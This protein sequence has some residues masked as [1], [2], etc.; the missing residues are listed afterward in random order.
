MISQTWPF[1][2][3]DGDFW[4][5]ISGTECLNY[6]YLDQNSPFINAG[7]YY[8]EQTHQVGKTTSIN[9][10]PD[11]NYI[12]LGFHYS[13]WFYTNAGQTTLIAD[14]DANCVID[15]NDLIFFVNHWL[16][17]FNSGTFDRVADL[18]KDG[19]IDFFDFSALAN[20]WM[21]TGEPDPNIEI[22]IYG[23]S[24]DGYINAGVYNFSP[25]TEQI[26]IYLDGE[27]LG[28]LMNFMDG[29]TFGI[30]TIGYGNGLHELKAVSKS[31]DGRITCSNRKS[32]YFNSLLSGLKC[33][34]DYRVDC[35][36]YFSGIYSGQNL[37]QVSVVDIEGNTAW[38]NTYS[39]N[40]NGFI[41]AGT[42]TSDGFYEIIFEEVPDGMFLLDFNESEYKSWVK[43]VSEKFDVGKY[44]ANNKSLIVCPD[45]DVTKGK[46]EA[47]QAAEYAFRFKNLKPVI[48]YLKNATYDNLT[49]CLKKL[50]IR[51]LYF[52]GHG[53]YKAPNKTTVT[54]VK[55]YDGLMVAYKRIDF[56]DPNIIPDGP[57]YNLGEWEK[58]A[59]SA[60]RMGVP[61]GK[62]KI[63]FFD[64]CY[65]ARKN[66]LNSP[67][68]DMSSTLGIYAN[69]R[70]Q[71]YIGW[72]NEAYINDI[73]NFHCYNLWDH[74]LWEHLRLDESF[75]YAL[76]YAN[77]H[78]IGVEH[79]GLEA[80]VDNYEIRGIPDMPSI[81]LR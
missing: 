7:S 12:N 10:V 36:Y 43:K 70:S 64:A 75:Y 8:I 23:D 57:S 45:K 31:S 73:P 53:G 17:D 24:N 4:S 25:S 65:S 69:D 50:P 26:F 80:P 33:S 16:S 44:D 68:G 9:G 49:Y 20:Q 18:N 30:E 58:T 52:V 6:F 32:V 27:Y 48:L 1:V 40:I 54:S 34:D 29:Q 51:H 41:P 74:L 55:L 66:I 2:H 19:S 14:F 56:I 72:K 38:S 42:F 28:E 79:P 5:I 76:I 39:D 35:N 11:S 63:T 61:T 77:E 46:F 81:Y 37:L 67:H 3:S 21:S 60:L 78:T 47:V 15:S 59:F 22:C 62:L 13:N 71:I